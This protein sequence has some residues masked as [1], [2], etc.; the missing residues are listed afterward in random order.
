MERPL[1]IL[2]ADDQPV[3]CQ[4]LQEH[5]SD[6]WHTVETAVNGREA[7]E[8]FRAGHFD[9]VIT[10]KAMPEMDGDQLAMAIKEIDPKQPIIL[11]TGFGESADDDHPSSSIDLVLSKPVSMLALRQALSQVLAA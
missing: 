5:L 1:H 7:L 11:L 9:L 8:K 2:V 3:L 4:L 6:D 10:D